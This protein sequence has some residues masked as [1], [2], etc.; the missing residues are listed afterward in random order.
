MKIAIYGPIGAGKTTVAN[1][2]KNNC[3]KNSKS[4]KVFSLASILKDISKDI[5]GRELVK[6]KDRPVLSLV[7][8]AAKII[9][10]KEDY[11]EFFLKFESVAVDVK[12][13]DSY[14]VAENLFLGLQNLGHPQVWIRELNKKVDLENMSVSLIDDMRFFEEE[15]FFRE[16]GWKIVKIEVDQETREKR[17][18][19]RD[20]VYNPKH[21]LDH[22]EKEWP[23]FVPDFKVR[24]Y[25]ETWFDD[26]NKIFGG[27]L[28]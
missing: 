1:L 23:K 11:E 10:T 8:Q 27:L 21:E 14:E 20:G 22:S 15:K 25:D 6:S 26:A 12:R 16:N 17:L 19:L 13:D 4:A 3:Q 7:G 28:W 2:I 24:N 9:R 5:L 18:I